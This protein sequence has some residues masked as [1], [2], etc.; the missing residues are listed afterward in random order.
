ME[1]LDT[2]QNQGPV[3]RQ[4]ATGITPSRTTSG[5][6]EA[7]V[8]RILGPQFDAKRI[9]ANSTKMRYVGHGVGCT[10][11]FRVFILF[12]FSSVVT[13]L[14]IARPVQDEAD[15]IAPVSAAFCASMRA[16][17]VLHAD[18]KVNCDRLR[19]VK[20]SYFGFDDKIHDDGEIVVMDAA[21]THVLRIFVKLRRMRF[22]IFKSR[23]MNDF[24]GDD[25]ASTRANNTSAF[26]DRNGGDS[27]SLHAYGLAI[28]LNPVQ[29]PY[30][31]RS[32]ATLRVDPPAG[33]DYINRMGERPW[34]RPRPGMAE[35]AVRTFADE[36]FLIWG[37][38]W[39]D[40]IDYQHFQ[41]SRKLAERLADLSP[42]EAAKSFDRVVDRFL[43]C[44]RKHPRQ[45]LPNPNCLTRAD[46]TADAA[47]PP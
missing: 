34:K 35:L 14:A 40:P 25:D 7:C 45:I 9:P 3:T 2:P 33:I 32:G 13:G 6:V 36:G 42:S 31:T 22:P 1:G 47:L 27:I 21:A 44:Q 43:A 15:G 8:P 37:G 20:F 5:G 29:N 19:L 4:L 18:P 11:C 16:H 12:V 23:P 38:Y 24:D 10:L 28:D 17:H 39:D 41:V 30:L 46:P 26:N